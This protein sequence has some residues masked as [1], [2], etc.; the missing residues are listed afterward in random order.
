MEATMNKTITLDA[1]ISTVLGDGRI[2][3]SDDLRALLTEITAGIAAADQSASTERGK[4]LDPATT[5]QEAEAAHQRAGME[6]LKAQR[7]RTAQPS[8]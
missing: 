5:P 3:S 7:Y 6:E 2:T 4:S 8:G 1:R